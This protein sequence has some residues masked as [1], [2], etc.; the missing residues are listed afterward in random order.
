MVRFLRA[1]KSLIRSLNGVC[2]IVV[3][4]KLTSSCAHLQYLADTVL[5]VT[6]CKVADYDGTLTIVKQSRLHGLIGSMTDTDVYA[7]RKVKTGII[8]ERIHLEPE[9]ERA[10]ENLGKK[11]GGVASV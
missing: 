3:D 5:R 9:E 8:V 4:E 11:K 7:I 2:L 6:S 10:D 1:L